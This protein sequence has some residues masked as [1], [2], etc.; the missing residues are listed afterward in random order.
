ME[1]EQILSLA[2]NFGILVLA[3][4]IIQKGMDQ[5][6]MLNQQYNGFVQTVLVQQQSNNEQ[7]ASLVEKLCQK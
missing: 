7:L 3:L 6:N 5:M 4:Y 1:L 2:D